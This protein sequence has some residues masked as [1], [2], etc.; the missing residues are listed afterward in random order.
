MRTAI[1]ALALGP[2]QLSLLALLRTVAARHGQ[3]ENAAHTIFTSFHRPN[4]MASAIGMISHIDPT[5]IAK[6]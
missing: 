6:P 4:A 2:S 5:E 1:L 3:F